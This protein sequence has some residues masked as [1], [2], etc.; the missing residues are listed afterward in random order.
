MTYSIDETHFSS[1]V[2]V[3]IKQITTYTEYDLYEAK[4]I[5]DLDRSPRVMNIL[6][7]AT[8]LNMETYRRQQAHRWV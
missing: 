4:H 1:E 2:E 6:T 8:R 3:Y 5:Q 7:F